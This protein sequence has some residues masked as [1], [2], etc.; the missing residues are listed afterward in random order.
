[1]R[2]FIGGLGIGVLIGMAVAPAT[3]AETRNRLRMRFETFREQLGLAGKRASIRV[4][5][6][7]EL[8]SRSLTMPL[9]KS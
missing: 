9:G 5:R 4:R 1:M 3:G 7:R 2:T 6:A 8:R